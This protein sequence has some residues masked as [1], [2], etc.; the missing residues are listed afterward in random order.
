[1]GN[2]IAAV[3][4]GIAA[5]VVAAV[6]AMSA[7]VGHTLAIASATP[8]AQDIRKGDAVSYERFVAES[9]ASSALPAS[10]MDSTFPARYSRISQR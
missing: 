3:F 1:M 4:A 10:L 6:W 2:E 5:A 9:S 7:K 8:R